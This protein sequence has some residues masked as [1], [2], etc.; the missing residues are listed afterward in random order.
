MDIFSTTDPISMK[1]LHGCTEGR[2]CYVDGQGDSFLTIHFESEA[3][4]QA[5]LAIPIEPS[6]LDLS[7]GTD[8]WVDEG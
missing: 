4:R 7:N 3:N 2:P 5:Y 6:S 8:E 1:D